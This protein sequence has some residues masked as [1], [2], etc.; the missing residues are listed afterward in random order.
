MS[1]TILID[2]ENPDEH[3][4]RKE[5]ES[6]R[7]EQL[8]AQKERLKEAEQEERALAKRQKTLADAAKSD[9]EQAVK[10]LADV[11]GRLAQKRS[12]YNDHLSMDEDTVKRVKASHGLG[13]DEAALAAARAGSQQASALDATV[14][15]ASIWSTSSLR[16]INRVGWSAAESHP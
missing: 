15:Y 9:H 6:R 13:Q 2:Y 8:R 10:E 4:Q 16:E 5:A 1:G 7:K 14:A 3:G 11:R 12:H